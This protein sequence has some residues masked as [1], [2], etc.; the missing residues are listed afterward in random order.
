MGKEVT[1]R[2]VAEGGS[3]VIS[4]RDV[5]KA[6]AAAHEI[7]ATGKRVAVHTGDVALPATGEAVVKAA[8][9]RFSLLY[10]LF[11]NAGIFAPKPFLE[12]DEAEY[13]RFLDII[14]KG[15]FFTA[16]APQKP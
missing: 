14:L 8:L 1:I 16:Q 9:E 6:E 13:D 3:V 10:V 2:F 4:G 12:V 11:N 15:T 5:A 7:D